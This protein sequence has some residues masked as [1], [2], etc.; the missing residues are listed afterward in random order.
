MSRFIPWNTKMS[1]SGQLQAPRRAVRRFSR[2]MDL[3]TATAGAV[4]MGTA[5]FAINVQIDPFGAATA[6]AKQAIY[7]FFAGGFLTRLCEGLA[8]KE[9]AVAG[10]TWAV[11]GPSVLAVSLTLLVHLIRGTP[12]PYWSTL[13]TI[14]IAPPSFLAWGANA[15]R[16]KAVA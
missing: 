6:A 12:A 15:R 9:P 7:T 5:V 1:V 4:V 10:L 2:W 8:V 13:P 14:I 11:V 16:R 3:R